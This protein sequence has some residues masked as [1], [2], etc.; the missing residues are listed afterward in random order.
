MAQFLKGEAL[1]ATILKTQWS[2][3]VSQMRLRVLRS[4]YEEV[5]NDF[6]VDLIHRF[7]TL[8]G[9][10][11]FKI[12]GS[13]ASSEMLLIWSYQ[14]KELYDQMLMSGVWAEFQNELSR[15]CFEQKISIIN[16]IANTYEIIE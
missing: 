11:D 12:L 5:K 6:M 3:H 4:S 2:G 16:S 13:Q 8:K 14:S 1:D 10:L 9:L 7:W 15:L